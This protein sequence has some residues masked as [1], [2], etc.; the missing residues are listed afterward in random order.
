MTARAIFTQKQALQT[1]TPFEQLIYTYTVAYKYNDN[2]D[3]H[4]NTS[5]H[6]PRSWR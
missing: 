6:G 5:V 1:H 3:D 2:N 4:D